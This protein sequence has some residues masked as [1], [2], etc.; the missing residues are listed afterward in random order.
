MTA[1]TLNNLV[2]TRPR[3]RCRL[4]LVDDDGEPKCLLRE[5]WLIPPEVGHELWL[6]DRMTQT[7]LRVVRVVHRINV[8]NE[9]NVYA[10][11]LEVHV[12]QI[13]LSEK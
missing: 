1:Q 3:A 10:S 5:L 8:E 9:A 4:T 13:S 2:E 12:E 11:A 6:D 7:R